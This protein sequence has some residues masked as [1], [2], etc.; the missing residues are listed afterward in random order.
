MKSTIDENRSEQLKAI[1]SDVRI[2]ILL[3]LREPGVHF[4]DQVTGDPDQI[5]VCVTLIGNK[6]EISQ[7]TVSRHLDILRR[8]GFLTSER[9]QSWSFYKRNGPEIQKFKDWFCSI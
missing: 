9:F 5:G 1:A 7:P 3:W 6:L 8:S 4:A 2:T